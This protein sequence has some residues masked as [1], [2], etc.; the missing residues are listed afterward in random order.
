MYPDGPPLA[1][2]HSH[3]RRRRLDGL[4]VGPHAIVFG[5]T[6]MAGNIWLLEPAKQDAH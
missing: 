4:G 5:R 3:E 1:V 6:E 2:Y